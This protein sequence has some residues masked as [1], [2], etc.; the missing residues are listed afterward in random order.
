MPSTLLIPPSVFLRGAWRA[1]M[2]S[3]ALSG[4]LL[5]LSGCASLLSAAGPTSRTITNNAE[6]AK[7]A[8]SSVP[9][10]LID[11]SAQTITPYIRPPD[12]V[13]A[14]D[15]LPASVPEINLVPGD[16]ITIMIADNAEA[17]L[18]AP[19][20]TGG[21]VFANVRIDAKGNISLPYTGV[22]SVADQ[23]PEQVEKAIVASLKGVAVAPVARVQLVGDF[24]SS[25]LVVGA[26][27][28]PGRVSAL[29]GPLTL[30]DAIN[31]SGGPV[32][33]PHLIR[34]VLRTGKDT[35]T[36]NYSDLLQSV[37]PVIPPHSEIIVE[38]DRKRFV[39]M[40]AVGSPGLHDL[41]SENPSLLEALGSVGGLQERIADASGIFIFRLT[42]QGPSQPPKATVFRLD[43]RRPESV[44]L[45]RLFLVQPED[46][47]YVTNAAVYE[48]QKIIAP[49][50]Q[51]L[52]LGRTFSNF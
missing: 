51:A 12:P 7:G 47:I 13:S 24:S 41:P 5:T 33:E 1:A 30:L 2:A 37:N 45:S 34:V 11:L 19:L 32:L 28:S 27:K 43:M 16:V 21:T 36:F 40:G 3:V 15:I 22:L 18:F 35:Q 4:V 50:A 29:K 23:T 9:Y 31:N 46:A 42:N 38:R 8:E 44:F 6:G 10:A 17:P 48:W 52:V 20:A 49:I 25:V 39:A 14:Q 26:V